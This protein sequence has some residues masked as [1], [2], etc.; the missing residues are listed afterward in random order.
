MRISNEQAARVL[1][2]IGDLLEI[3]GGEDAAKAAAYRR[4]GRAILNFPDDITDLHRADRLREIPGVGEALAR[5]LAELLETGRI[6]YLE[7][8]SEGMPA[9]V[10]D[11]LRIPGVGART[12]G[13]LFRELGIGDLEELEAAARD[14]R[15]RHVAGFGPKKENAVLQGLAL[16]RGRSDRVPLAVA[17][18]VALSLVEAIKALPGVE[19]ASV[20]GSVRRWMETVGGVDVVLALK[21]DAAGPILIDLPGIRE[22]LPENTG[23]A[24][25]LDLGS[26]IEA[27]VHAVPAESYWFALRHYTGSR[28]HND[29]LRARAEQLGLEMGRDGVLTREGWPLAARSEEEVYRRLDLDFIPPELREGLDEV[30]RAAAGTLPELLTTADIRGDL[31]VHTDWS[32]GQVTLEELAH[33]AQAMGYEY[34]AV[35]DHSKSLAMARGL[36]ERRLGEQVEAIGR[37]NQELDGFR[38]LTGIEVDILAD[39][40]LD[41]T[42][43]SL[44][45]LDVVV[46]SVHSALR[47]PPDRM[48]ARLTAAAKH[49]HVDIIGHPTG[50]VVGRREPAAVDLDALFEVAADTGTWLEMSASPDRLDL[51]DSAARRAVDAGCRVAVSTDAHSPRTLHDMVYGVATARRAWLGPDAVAN[52]ST[53]PELRALLRRA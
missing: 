42:D 6:G 51:G 46:A 28:A 49:E 25:R 34:A 41:L 16:L 39:G 43:S 29:R 7:D 21:P 19:R 35:T 27:D 36:D 12:A 48:T 18:P 1:A 53:W 32:D 44:A 20:A 38:L 40:K 31:H 3:R 9:G 5:K 4:A 26:G 13:V 14:G 17:H 47:Q 37:L 33:L 52:T 23:S 10:L 50:R 45:E 30:D 11:L 15:L 8:L 24:T 2:L 22:I